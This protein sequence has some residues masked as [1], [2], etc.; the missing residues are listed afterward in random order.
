LSMYEGE[1]AYQR[2]VQNTG[3]RTT[4]D[5]SVVADPST[6]VWVADT[7]DIS[8][9]NPF[10]I[11]GG[12]SLSAPIWAG[13]FALT[14][15][16]R[17]AAGKAPLNTS[18]PTATLEGLYTLPQADYNAITSGTNWGYDAAAGYNLVTGLGT[19][20]ANK[21][22]ADLIAYSGSGSF[23]T[24]GLVAPINANLNATGNPVGASPTDPITIF[25]VLAFPGGAESDLGRP[26]GQTG[27]AANRPGLIA[28][29]GTVV[30]SLF[31]DAAPANSSPASPAPGYF[32]P[33]TTESNA[34]GSAPTGRTLS[35]ANSFIVE[36]GSSAGNSATSVMGWQ[37]K[38]ID[39]LMLEM[40]GESRRNTVEEPVGMDLLDSSGLDAIFDDEGSSIGVIPVAGSEMAMPLSTSGDRTQDIALAVDE[41]FVLAA[42][43]L[44]WHL[45]FRAVDKRRPGLAR[46]YE[47]HDTGNVQSH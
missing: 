7:Y 6:G 36:V 31:G 20:I 41:L 15:Q 12:T 37:G 21:L 22:V 16:G 39:G 17:A 11:V 38:L 33:A 19:P 29:E 9:T 5:V 34:I 14:N 1:A 10:E 28:S 18:G 23:A 47:T 4:P 46:V 2:G 40:N 45:Q 25:N 30:R 44:A 26:L 8:G 43:L 13:L 27:P 35:T 32:L 42:P 24:G 3:H